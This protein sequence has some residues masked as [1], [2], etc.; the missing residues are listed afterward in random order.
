MKHTTHI[1]T[2]TWLSAV[3]CAVRGEE[4]YPRDFFNLTVVHDIIFDGID[5]MN[6]ADSYQTGNITSVGT[7]VFDITRLCLINVY[8][9]TTVREM[10]G[11]LFDRYETIQATLKEVKESREK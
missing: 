1:N 11:D 8:D 2:D 5:R 6:I 4:N 7:Q 3:S 9:L 10:V